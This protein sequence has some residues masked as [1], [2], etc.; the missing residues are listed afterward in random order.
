VEE[1]PNVGSPFFG[2]YPSEAFLKVTKEI[3]E[4]F[5]P[6]IYAREFRGIFEAS[7]Y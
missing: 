1:K 2:A 5:I 7:A 6:V 4:H 3:S